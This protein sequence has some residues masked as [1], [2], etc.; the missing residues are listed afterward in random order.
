MKA[1]ALFIKP[2][3]STLSQPVSQIVLQR[4]YGI[5]GDIHAQVGSPRQILI[6]S[7]PVLE[8]YGLQPGNLHEN[9]LV[10][11][12]IE[13]LN[14]GQV[15]Q[16]A[17]SQGGDA[18]CNALIRL[19]FRCEP[20]FNLDRIRPNLAK[21]LKGKRGFLGIVIQDGIVSKGDRISITPTAFPPL[22][23][24][25]KE[26]FTEFVA[27]IPRGKVV[28]TR[29]IIQAIGVTRAHYRILPTWI[30]QFSDFLPTHRIISTEGLLMTQL[31]REQAQRLRDEGIKFG[32]CST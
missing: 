22:S 14:S 4:G 32:N 30:R 2:N 18:S 19:T 23:D 6:A 3:R 13:S 31:N 16:I 17:D 10:D 11:G 29:E 15:L 20:C 7:Q 25:P 27:R 24:I 21:Q 5:V 8:Q 1:I 28:R 9:I 26:R 12:A